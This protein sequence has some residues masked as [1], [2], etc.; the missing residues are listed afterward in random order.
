VQLADRYG[1]ATPGVVVTWGSVTGA[2]AVGPI[3]VATD[4]NGI[5][6]AIYRLGSMPGANVIRASVNPLG[7]TADFAATAKGFSDQIGVSV[8]HSCALDEDGIA[9]L[10]GTEPQG[11][12]G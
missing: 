2:G 10:L 11:A 12:G 1:N 4:A 6:R 3:N 9:L 5:A 8:Q 7:L